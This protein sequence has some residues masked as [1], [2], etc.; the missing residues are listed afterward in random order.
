MSLSDEDRARLE[1][2]SAV[3]LGFPHESLRRPMT[4]QSLTGGGASG[5]DLVIAATHE[6]RDQ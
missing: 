5:A 3:E 2:V 6:A 4:M 1:Q